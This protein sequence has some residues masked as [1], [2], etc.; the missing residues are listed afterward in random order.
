MIV[1]NGKPINIDNP[2]LCKV[3]LSPEG[4]SYKQNDLIYLKDCIKISDKYDSEINKPPFSFN[5]HT[6]E[7][8]FQSE[9]KT[10]SLNEG[11][12]LF[13][14]P[15]G[16]AVKIYDP[17]SSTNSVLI[18]EKCNSRCIIC[19][20]PLKKKDSLGWIDLTLHSIELMNP[21]MECLGITGGEPTVK[22]DDL[23]KII[24]KC[25]IYLPNTKLQLLTNARLLRSFNKTKQLAEVS[26]EKLF[27][28][29]PIYSDIDTVHDKI[30]GS[31]GAFWESIEGLYNLER[32][33]IFIELR[34]V[35]TKE[36]C[37]RLPEYAE[38]IYRS[39]PFIGYIA[40]M[41]IEPIGEALK[42]IKQLWI[43]PV[44][45]MKYLIKAIKILKRRDINVFLYNFQLCTLPKYLWPIAKK[46]ISEW[47]IIYMDECEKC[48]E[49]NR[50]GGFFFSAHKYKSK[51]ISPIQ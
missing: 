35:I 14:T 50:C 4:E 15:E 3:A 44:D 29:V 51:Y 31:K 37:Y 47:K 49:K 18:T 10:I 9:E 40:F 25:N 13:I 5:T 45:Y 19:P 22:W 38:F 48:K 46:S 27:V 20:Q 16:T 24:E 41:A 30:C 23:I 8:L 42:N 26:N 11:D 7:P 34:N 2:T 1:I 39:I 6:K 28:G 12:I 32:S 43:D 17:L 21:D 33:S 36:N